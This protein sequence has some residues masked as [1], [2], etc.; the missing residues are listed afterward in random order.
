MLTPWDF[1]IENSNQKVL[2]ILSSMFFFS[3][4]KR[5]RFRKAVDW[6]YGAGGGKTISRI[7]GY[8]EEGGGEMGYGSDGS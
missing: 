8:R 6:L 3:S 2:N 4:N 7:G 5:L 1:F